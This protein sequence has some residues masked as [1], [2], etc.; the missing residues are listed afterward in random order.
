[1]SIVVYT[2]SLIYVLG[3]FQIANGC[4]TSKK[5]IIDTIQILV[6]SIGLESLHPLAEDTMIA[7][8]SESVELRICKVRALDDG[9]RPKKSSLASSGP[10]QPGGSAVA[11]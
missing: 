11:S 10:S 6:L 4:P 9:T 7:N 5:D 8:N 2:D 1:M 3:V